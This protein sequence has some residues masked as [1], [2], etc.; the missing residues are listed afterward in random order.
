ML[1]SPGAI[2]GLHIS[3]I[4]LFQLAEIPKHVVGHTL[5]LISTVGQREGNFSGGRVL[6]FSKV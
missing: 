4:G 1:K 2:P 5:D 6:G 3:V